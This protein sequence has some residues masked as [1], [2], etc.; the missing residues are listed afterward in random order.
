MPA[1]FPHTYVVD[2]DWSGEPTAQGTLKSEGAPPLR[3]GPPRQ[4]DGPGGDWS[5]EELLLAAVG[6]CTMTT[7]FALA[8]RKELAVQRYGSHVEGQLDKTREG[9]VFTSVVLHVEIE[10][11]SADVQ[12]ARDLV[13]A[14]HGYCI[15]T[16]A[17][18]P[19]VRL[20]ASVSPAG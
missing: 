3:T 8:R 15:V 11:A 9:L 19:E 17:L 13:S 4:F 6:S 5:P 14:A 7:F 2:L 12:L 18:R 16:N 10:V 1:P 20:E